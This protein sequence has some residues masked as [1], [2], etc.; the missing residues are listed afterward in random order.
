VTLLGFTFDNETNE[1]IY[2]SAG[3]PSPILYSA[4]PS[5]ER[6]FGLMAVRSTVLGLSATA[7]FKPLVYKLKAGDEI[8]AYTDGLPINRHV[9]K[10]NAFFKGLTYDFQTAPK[11]LL[12]A[13][14]ASETEKSGK[15]LD[16]DVSIVF[17][18]VKDAEGVAKPEPTTAAG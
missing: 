17:F 11:A 6:Q 16:D 18:R 14:W 13:V 8:V 5:G 12:D 15:A 9:R 10:V 3:H 4:K 1:L 7:A 2:I